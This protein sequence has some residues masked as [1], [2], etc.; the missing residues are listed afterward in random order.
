MDFWQRLL[1][2]QA[3]STFIG[4]MQDGVASD[5]LR[6]KLRAPLL[7]IA[8]MILAIY[9][10]ATLNIQKARTTLGLEKRSEEQT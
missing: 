4:L 7:K 9:P 10:D 1:L 2:N 6:E 3:I 5:A 8:S